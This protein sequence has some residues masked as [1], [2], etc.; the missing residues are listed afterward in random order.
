MN[1][2]TAWDYVQFMWQVFLYIASAYFTIVFQI[3]AEGHSFAALN[4]DLFLLAGADGVIYQYMPNERAF[5][6][7]EESLSK[8]YLTTPSSIMIYSKYLSCNNNQI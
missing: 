4:T 2:N 7:T 6:A 3:I 1:K 8:H 5:E